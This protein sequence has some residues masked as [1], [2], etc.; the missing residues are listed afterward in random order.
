MPPCAVSLATCLVLAGCASTR[1]AA[2]DTPSDLDMDSCRRDVANLRGHQADHALA[3][4]WNRVEAL[5]A[6]GQRQPEA[7]RALAPLIAAHLA[8]VYPRVFEQSIECR[9]WVCRVTYRAAEPAS[10]HPVGLSNETFG[11]RVVGNDELRSRRDL[12]EATGLPVRIVT[13]LL[14]L[15]HP[16]G[17][18]RTNDQLQAEAAAAL[19]SDEAAC[20]SELARLRLDDQRAR[21]DRRR[22]LES[23][24]PELAYEVGAPNPRLAAATAPR[25]LAAFG[26]P[27]QP[28]ETVVDCRGQV[29]KLLLPIDDGRRRILW[30]KRAMGDGYRVYEPSVNGQATTLFWALTPAYSNTRR[31]F[32]EVIRDVE[33]AR[34][35]CEKLAPGRGGL[36]A[37]IRVPAT[38]AEKPP[39]EVALTFEG[40]LSGTPLGRCVA[41]RLQTAVRAA[42]QKGPFERSSLSY[43]F[44]FPRRR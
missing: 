31:L 10:G 40:S 20:R 11:E 34:P 29:C 43:D 35:R 2:P 17:E 3:A 15:R 37:S 41:G 25:V 38:T 23:R 5:F 9:T 14:L 28:A 6:E 42:A 33:A 36:T 21:A 44:L 27:A 39:A 8:R 32:R 13:D 16:A 18:P 7:E 12:D 24:Q 30:G 1:S 4:R 19:P 22:L 26:L